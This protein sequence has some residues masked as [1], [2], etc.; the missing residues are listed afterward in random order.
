MVNKDMTQL[1]MS[2]V[3]KNGLQSVQ[4]YGLEHTDVAIEKTEFL[5]AGLVERGVLEEVAI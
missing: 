5:L 2:T 3:T 1:K 4:L